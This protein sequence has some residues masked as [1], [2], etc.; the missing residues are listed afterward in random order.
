MQHKNKRQVQVD[1]N[2][3]EWHLIWV[4]KHTPGTLQKLKT[5]IL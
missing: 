5:K 3:Q 2:R 1:T 4:L